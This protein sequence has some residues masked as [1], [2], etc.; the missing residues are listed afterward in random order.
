MTALIDRPLVPEIEMTLAKPFTVITQ[1]RLSF[2]GYPYGCHWGIS[3]M[4]IVGGNTSKLVNNCR[5]NGIVSPTDLLM[6]F[7]AFL[8]TVAA[9][10]NLTV[11]DFSASGKHTPGL[12]AI[13]G[14][15]RL[16]PTMI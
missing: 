3:L 8:R 2:H 6:V 12:P 1:R 4:Q 7:E 16:E 10:H 11:V 13:S 14:Q 5:Y 9:S 15:F